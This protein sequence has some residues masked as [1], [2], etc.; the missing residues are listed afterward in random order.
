MLSRTVRSVVRKSGLLGRSNRVNSV[1]TILTSKDSFQQQP[2]TS[3]KEDI[4]I[5]S[6]FPSI[7]YPNVSID[8][9]VWADL[10]KWGNKTAVVSMCVCECVCYVRKDG[11][12]LKLLSIPR[13]LAI[14]SSHLNRKFP[15]FCTHKINRLM[16]LR[17]VQ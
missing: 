13:V 4:T 10:N 3:N 5:Y 11:G 14:F 17:D 1:R 7:D 8:Q 15:L 12:F 6:P 16:A 9:Y 2:L